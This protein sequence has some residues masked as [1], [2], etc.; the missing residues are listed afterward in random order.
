[1]AEVTK[2]VFDEKAF[3]E[4]LDK[5]NKLRDSMAG[6]SNHNSHLWYN[7]HVKPSADAYAKGDRTEATFANLMKIKEEVP[8]VNPKLVSTDKEPTK[9]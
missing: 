3:K 9:A 5:L 8:P 6:K 2:F 4:K 1:M 7:K